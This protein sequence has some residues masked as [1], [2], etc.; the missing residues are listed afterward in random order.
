MARHGR[1]NR[2]AL[3]TAAPE[4]PDDELDRR[5]KRYAILAMVFVA[6]FTAGA[7]A[8]RHTLLAL[9]L[10][11][12]AMV[13]LLAAVITANVRSRPRRPTGLGHLVCGAQQLPRPPVRQP[14]DNR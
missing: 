6:C 5:R 11:G 14:G 12:I 7:F 10:C 13:A 2:P 9:L 8:H 4:S 1:S 3:I